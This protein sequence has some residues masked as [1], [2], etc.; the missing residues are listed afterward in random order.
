[1]ATI[2]RLKKYTKIITHKLLKNHKNIILYP[3]I[4]QAHNQITRITEKRSFKEQN[5]Q[6]N[7][8]ATP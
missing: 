7:N 6:Y 8:N 4:K 2:K 3:S 5:E 1:M